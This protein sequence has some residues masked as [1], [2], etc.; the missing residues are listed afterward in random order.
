LAEVESPPANEFAAVDNAADESE[1]GLSDAPPAF[2]FP[3]EFTPGS[4]I[5][6]GAR[7]RKRSPV[8]LLVMI[9]LGGMIGVAG[10]YYALLWIR[11]PSLDFL[12]VAPYLPQ[13]MLPASF[14]PREQ[15]LAVQTPPSA[16]PKVETA[17]ADEPDESAP[18]A[19]DPPANTADE[20]PEMQASYTT[21]EEPAAEPAPQQDDR[22]AVDASEPAPLDVQPLETDTAAD[23]GL[24]D[25]TV[26][27]ETSAPPAD[28]ARIANA[29]TFTADEL[30]AALEE[31]KKAQPALVSGNLADSKEVARAKGYSYSML[32]DLAQKATFA[33]VSAPSGTTDPLQQAVEELFRQ[34]LS[35]QHA[36]SE[37]ALIFPKWLASRNR[38]HGGVFFA[39]N[40]AGSENKGSVT[41]YRAELD[42][43]ESIAVL[44]PAAAAEQLAQSSRPM[45]VVGWVV[46]K[47][48]EQ[49]S[50][51]TGNAP[52]AIWASKLIA[53][54]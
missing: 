12:N 16:P 8:R 13:A 54:D 40:I 36:R 37:V 45:A 7:R 1:D 11:G 17:Q 35:D 32:A 51:Y 46:D 23:A 20:T 15:Q 4:A 49:V 52:Q 44:V 21:T 22:Y 28:E 5:A 2:A 3:T 47:P 42:G 34:T 18:L 48:A 33:E 6:R 25:V 38:K 19:T 10:G 39:A 26:D 14:K 43:G 24:T 27:G 53:L 41:E 30:S 50:G 9:L 29:P 31:A